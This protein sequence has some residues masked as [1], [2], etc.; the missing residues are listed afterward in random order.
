M[1]MYLLHDSDAFC[2][3]FLLSIVLE[4]GV[5]TNRRGGPALPTPAVRNQLDQLPHQELFEFAYGERL[6]VT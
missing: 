2:Y 5:H 6:C 1:F 4:E 3:F